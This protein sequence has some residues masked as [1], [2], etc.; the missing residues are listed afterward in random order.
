MN[1]G[2]CI[3]TTHQWVIFNLAHANLNSWNFG[4]SEIMLR[5]LSLWRNGKI[6]EITFWSLSISSNKV[7]IFCI[8]KRESLRAGSIRVNAHLDVKISVR[9]QTNVYLKCLQSA[10]KYKKCWR[11]VTTDNYFKILHLRLQAP[12]PISHLF[13]PL[14]KF[15]FRH[16]GRFE[17]QYNFL[18]LFNQLFGIS[19]SLFLTFSV[20]FASI[21]MF[22]IFLICTLLIW[23]LNYLFHNFHKT[24]KHKI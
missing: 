24:T 16:S 17:N 23:N 11:L 3:V 15:C 4:T 13:C 12:F 20:N 14:S 5:G 1:S 18:P 2:Y 6:C 22:I 10:W 19:K 7:C 8:Q 9:L 21:Y